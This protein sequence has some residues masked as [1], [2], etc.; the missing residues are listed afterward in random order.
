MSEITAPLR[1]LLKKH[2]PCMA[3]DGESS[4][5]IKKKKRNPFSRSRSEMLYLVTK[6]VVPQT[7]VSNKGL[8]AVLLQDGFPVAY[9]SR[10]MTKT[11]ERYAQIEKELLWVRLQ[12]DCREY[13]LTQ[14]KVIYQPDL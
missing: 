10:T 7:D 14:A 4:S 2:V 8:S 6:P 1:E 5:C 11:Q 13:A 9:T 3:L 12:P